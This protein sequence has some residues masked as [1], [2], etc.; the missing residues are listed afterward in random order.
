M[1]AN[2]PIN[3]APVMKTNTPNILDTV[4]KKN[5]T[6]DN[7]MNLATGQPAVNAEMPKTSMRVENAQSQIRHDIAVNQS[8]VDVNS[9]VNANNTAKSSFLGGNKKIT[10]SYK[11][12]E[13][14]DFGGIR[15]PEFLKKNRNK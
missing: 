6:S 13:E 9:N 5:P 10:P 11:N 15:I 7:S 3:Q 1:A 12:V 8:N 2:K 4:T 14:S